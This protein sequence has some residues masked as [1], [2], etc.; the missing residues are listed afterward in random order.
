MVNGIFIFDESKFSPELREAILKKIVTIRDG[1]AYYSKNAG[2]GYSGIIQHIPLKRLDIE[3]VSQQ[4]VQAAIS[5]AQMAQFA[6][7][8]IS[9]SIILASV[10]VQTNYLAEKINALQK[11]IDIVSEKMNTQN[12]VYYMDKISQYF[13]SVE[14]AR[15]LL[16]DRALV[17]ETRDISSS[18]FIIL[19]KERTEV[20]LLIDNLLTYAQKMPEEFLKN[21]LDFIILMLDIM[22]KA[23]YIEVQFLDRYK[24]FLLAN[25]TLE[26]SKNL[27]QKT[28]KLFKNWCNQSIDDQI[29][30]KE[31]HYALTFQKKM[32]DLKMLFVSANE[33]KRL[34]ERVELP[35][36]QY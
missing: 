5:K 31:S 33:D 4:G 26:Q 20:L 34:L 28:F 25:H 12:V 24:K 32:P 15:S 30:G 35:A 21:M 3:L 8:G 16:M 13:A 19:A 22:P 18:L 29:L 9:T 27:Y 23:I 7:M 36:L 10:V 2:E 17:E 14:I 6:A 11:S 1:V